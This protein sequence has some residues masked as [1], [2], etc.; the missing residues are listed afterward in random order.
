[1]GCI[2]YFEGQ[3]KDI[4]SYCERLNKENLNKNIKY[5]VCNGVIDIMHIPMECDQLDLLN[6]R[7]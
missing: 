1:M 3:D 5:V 6:M 2:L 7:Q 4:N